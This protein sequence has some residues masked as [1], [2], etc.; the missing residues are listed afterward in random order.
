[1][2]VVFFLDHK[3]TLLIIAEI[4]VSLAVSWLVRGQALLPARDALF[5]PNLIIRVVNIA[6]VSFALWLLTYLV[7][8]RLAREL[9]KLADYDALTLLHNRRSMR[10]L[11]D[12]VMKRTEKGDGTFSLLMCDLDNFK[13]INDTYGHDC[14]DLILKTVANIISCDVRKD[15]VVFRYGGEE[16]LVMVRAT[17]EITEHVAERIRSDIAAERIS[18][19]DAAISITVTIGVASYQ[20]HASVDELI[21]LADTR[22]YAGKA[23]GKNQ[24]V[25]G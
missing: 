2:L 20:P 19:N 4:D 7:E 14:G 3:Y 5:V 11:I 17:P 18:Y 13:R 6:L 23:N 8:K 16:I 1:M 24:V 25:N 22:L 10:G 21:K 15:D 12:G 9:E